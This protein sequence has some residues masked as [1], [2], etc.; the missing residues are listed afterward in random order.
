MN[1]EIKFRGKCVDTGEWVYG[2]YAKSR[3]DHKII[4]IIEHGKYEWVVTNVDPETVGQYTG[5]KDKNGVEIYEGDVICLDYY[6]GIQRG[7]YILSHKMKGEICFWDK[8]MSFCIENAINIDDPED[9][10]ETLAIICS[11]DNFRNILVTG[12]IHENT[13]G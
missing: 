2:Y 3:K 12:N 5:I 6:P 9:D 7:V 13:E 1:R 8:T 4:G 10:L 11:G